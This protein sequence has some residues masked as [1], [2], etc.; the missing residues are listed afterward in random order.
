MTGQFHNLY[1]DELYPPPLVGTTNMWGKLYKTKA[2]LLLN[3]Y[4]KY[5]NHCVTLYN[6][7]V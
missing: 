1:P 5:F 4:G 7:Y 3:A 6:V 2:Q